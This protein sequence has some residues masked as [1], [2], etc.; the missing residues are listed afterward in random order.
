MITECRLIVLAILLFPFLSYTSTA[1]V[2]NEFQ[3]SNSVTASDEDGEYEDWIEIYNETSEAINLNGYGLSD[4]Y[5]RPY[6]WVFPDITIEPGDF[7]LVWASGKNRVNPTAPLHTNFSISASSEEIILTAPDGSRID[8]IEPMYLPTDI[9]YG[10]KPDGSESFSYFSEPT[11][12]HS[13]TTTGYDGI[14]SPPVFSHDSGFYTGLITLS[15]QA[16]NDAEIR[17]TTGGSNPTESTGQVYSS[18]LSIFYSGVIRARAFKDNYIPSETAALQFVRMDTGLQGF[19][20]DLPLVVMNQYVE[21]VGPGDRK[22]V[23]LYFSDG[24]QGARTSLADD[25]VLHSLGKANIRGT[26]S[27]MFPKK[28]YGFHLLDSSDGNR[29]EELFGMPGDHNWIL[30]APYSDKSLMRNV[31]AYSLAE[32]MGWYAPRTRF[33]ELFEHLG[34]G[35]LSYD[36]YH[37]VYVLVER[38]KW[39]DDRVNITKIGPGDNSE[40]EI[41]GGYIIKKDRLNE[42]QSGFTT[43]LGTTLAFARPQEEDV[44]PQQKSWIRQYMSDFESAIFSSSF[45]DPVNGYQAFIDTDS[46]IDHL[47]ITELL[48]EI[49][50]YRLSTFM[51][52]DRNGKL[53]MGPVWDFNLSLGNAYYIEGWN[54]VGWY[55]E[56]LA[57]ESECYIG[58]GV[59][60][61]YL[62]L[63][64]D[65]EFVERLQLRWWTLRQN[66]IS[67]DN[68]AAMIAENR[69]IL[70]ESQQRNFQRWQ[71]LGEYVW[72]NYF[73]AD[74]WLEELEWMEDF[75]LTRANWIDTQMGEE[76]V[77]SE[78][79]LHSFWHFNSD[80]PNNTPLESISATYPGNLNTYI[81]YQS[82]L[83]GYPFHSGHPNW[84]KASMERRNRPTSINYSEQANDGNAYDA[85]YMRGMQV[86]QPFMGDAG[87]NTLIFHPD[88]QQYGGFRFSFAA[89][90]EGA[91]DQ[92]I[93]DYSVSDGEPE[94]VTT[95]LSQ[96]VYALS[97]SYQLYQI[98]FAG[99]DEADYNPDFKI[100]VR[101]SGDDMTEDGGNRT[102]FNNIMLE[103]QSTATSIQE[104]E[105]EN[106]QTISLKQN[107]PNPF[108][109][110]TTIQ[111]TLP[112]AGEVRID[113]YNVMGQRV[114]TVVNEHQNAGSHTISFDATRLASGVYL[115]K[116][117]T[118][119]KVLIRKMT[120]IK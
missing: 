102:T 89:M 82:A 10:R 96:S 19:D 53:V 59:R 112:E 25:L 86:R 93:I 31:I 76:P 119:G 32:S 45:G 83:D 38:I 116:L 92:L 90:D 113:V 74:T 104:P 6:R 37:G 110:S 88:A 73:V 26:S 103:Y 30:Y 15:L 4:D 106:P 120:L 100:R 95:G 21:E 39:S 17:Y 62:R 34:T 12:G 47:I 79:Q 64:Q 99:I 60:D 87:E 61:W 91:A 18:P 94:W 52:K 8:E 51:H 24:G 54:P 40:P 97:S 109:P 108:N 29:K 27:Q 43:D 13:N 65:P 57:Q 5:D 48:K 33:V 69:Q 66:L 84:R 36:N 22:P 98:D 117:Q 101:F 35:P 3:A 9:S 49:D 7:L 56:L 67:D 55:Y 81:E 115:Y 44:T 114:A 68:L 72:P 63:L 1:Q 11:P 111:Y 118:S 71:I 14:A 105:T 107:Y 16:G 75:L 80:M 2:L 20:S 70:N 42:G 85:G 78:Y 23:S 28:M 46:F 50:G 77:I 41:T 58:C